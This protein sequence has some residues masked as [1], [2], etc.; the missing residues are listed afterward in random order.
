MGTVKMKD[1]LTDA[2][3]MKLRVL[4]ARDVLK[5]MEAKKIKAKSGVYVDLGTRYSRLSRRTV[6]IQDVIEKAKQPCKVCLLG[7]AMLAFAHRHDE[8]TAGSRLISREEC[9][10][11]LER[12]F[13]PV[14]LA[15]LEAAFEGW[16]PSDLLDGEENDDRRLTGIMKNVIANKGVFVPSKLKAAVKA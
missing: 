1:D 11:P 3:R 16:G 14:E 13:S 15:Q 10:D 7:A 9:V 2:Q 8:V 4:L 12:L 6:D 5:L